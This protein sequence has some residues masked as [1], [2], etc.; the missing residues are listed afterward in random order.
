M[1]CL[2]RHAPHFYKSLRTLMP[3]GQSS[4]WS[5]GSILPRI[6]GFVPLSPTHF[7]LGQVPHLRLSV[8][9]IAPTRLTYCVLC[10]TFPEL[11]LKFALPLYVALIVC[12]PKPSVEIVRLAVPPLRFTVSSVVLPS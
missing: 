11:P 4:P 2:C 8:V 6:P 3:T 7:L 10:A 9:T 1:A 5:T 12:V